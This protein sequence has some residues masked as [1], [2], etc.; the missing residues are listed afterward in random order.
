MIPFDGNVDFGRV[1]EHIRKSGFDGTL[2]LEVFAKDKAY[3]GMS[4][5]AFITRAAQ[6][7]ERL[8]DML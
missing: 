8:R 2:M 5:E 4:A 3:D 1:A 7:A 6:A